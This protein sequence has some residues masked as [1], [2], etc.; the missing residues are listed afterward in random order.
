MKG[1][2]NMD[3]WL[4]VESKDGSIGKIWHFGTFEETL[5]FGV[6]FLKKDFGNVK[7]N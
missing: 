5:D 2:F 7:K 3:S 6:E 4:F 1:D